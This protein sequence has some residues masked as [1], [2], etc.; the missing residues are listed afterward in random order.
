MSITNW[1][2]HNGGIEYETRL[3]LAIDRSSELPLYFRYIAGNIGDVSTLANT[4]TEMK[5]LGLA[6][7]SALIDAGY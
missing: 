3:I 1:G 2:Y 4:I 5:K 7:S 6:T